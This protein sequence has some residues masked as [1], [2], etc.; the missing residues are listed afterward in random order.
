MKIYLFYTL[1]ALWDNQGKIKIYYGMV[2][3]KKAAI[4]KKFQLPIKQEVINDVAL[5]E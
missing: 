3:V 4:G 2:N 5:L 1:K